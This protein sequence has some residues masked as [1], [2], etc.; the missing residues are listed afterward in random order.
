MHWLLNALY[1]FT[2]YQADFYGVVNQ[3]FGCPSFWLVCILT[4]S[5]PMILD[6]LILHLQR[7]LQPTFLHVMQE[8]VQLQRETLIANADAF[9]RR[10]KTS[11]QITPEIEEKWTMLTEVKLDTQDLNKKNTI[12][13]RFQ[14]QAGHTQDKEEK[15]KNTL[16]KTMLRF[17]NQTGSNFESAAQ[18]KYQVHDRTASAAERE[19]KDH[20]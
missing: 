20:K 17:R 1:S 7:Q 6:L 19:S 9:N 3:M 15:L 11:I 5:I 18:A 4:V 14:Q 10:S 12:L 8:T 16:V 2:K 13:G